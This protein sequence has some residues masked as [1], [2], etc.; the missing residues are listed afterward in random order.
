ME[1]VLIV[2][3]GVSGSGKSFHANKLQTYLDAKLVETD[4]LR[5]ELLCDVH[6]QT[7]NGR[8][9]AEARRRVN[10]FLMEGHNVIIDAT[11]LNPKDRK[12]WIKIG[13]DNGAEVHARF[14]NVSS[15][16]AKKR[17]GQ[18]T[19]QVPEWVIDKQLSKLQPPSLAEGFNLIVKV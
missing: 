1:S 14:I 16:L 12:D 7:Q 15:E 18:R 9:F 2:M 3:I 17:N 19:R 4:A 10:N 8:I 11:N 13:R 5:Q 6:D